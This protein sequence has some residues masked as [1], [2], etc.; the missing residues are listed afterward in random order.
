MV[1]NLPANA[2]RHKRREF[3]PWVWKIPW[4]RARQPTSLLL[5]GKSHGQSSLV[6][7][8]PWGRKES[9]RDL[10]VLHAYPCRKKPPK[11][12][13]S[14]LLK[15]YC[16]RTLS[17]PQCTVKITCVCAGS[18]NIRVT[19][20]IVVRP[21]LWLSGTRLHEVCLYFLSPE[22]PFSLQINSYAELQ[23]IDRWK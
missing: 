22:I 14:H 20:L 4:R 18:Q 5:P 19:C 2:R 1:K 9:R 13:V 16:Y 3:D 7:Y 21:F 23:Y 17:R 8:S 10:S 12:C 11:T 15:A 6:G